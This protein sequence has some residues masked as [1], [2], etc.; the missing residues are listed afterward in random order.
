M[1]GAWRQKTQIVSLLSKRDSDLSVGENSNN[2]L[3]W[4]VLN[5]SD[6]VSYEMLNSLDATQLTTDVIDSGG[7]TPLYWAGKK[8]NMRKTKGW[9]LYHGAD[10]SL[11]MFGK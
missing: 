10:P 9:L 11:T 2:V 6:D 1:E 4:I 8:P 5:N 3:N 7:K